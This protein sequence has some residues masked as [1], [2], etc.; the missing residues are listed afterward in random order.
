MVVFLPFEQ[1]GQL[2]LSPSQDSSLGET[3]SG[4]KRSPYVK[5][6]ASGDLSTY[7]TLE[8]DLLDSVKYFA[9]ITVCCMTKI[10]DMIKLTYSY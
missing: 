3:C 4:S 2:G 6:S 1:R 9:F 10:S 8:H 7:P 5:L